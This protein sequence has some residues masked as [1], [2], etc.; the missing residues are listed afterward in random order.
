MFLR[1]NLLLTGFIC[2]FLFANAFPQ[3]GVNKINHIVILAQENRSFDHYFGQLRQYR[4]QN[5]YADVSFDGLPQFNPTS[6]L[7]PLHGPAPTNQG[8][9]PA[10]PPPN[11]CKVDANSPK[12]TSLELLTEC[13]ENTSPSW[14]EAHNDWDINDPTGLQAAKLNGFVRAGANYARNNQPIFF[15]TDGI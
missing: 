15:D 6:G 14:N 10:L 9:D 13:I 8:C 5:G 2:S 3:T 1:R 12:V 11:R 7:T 4:A